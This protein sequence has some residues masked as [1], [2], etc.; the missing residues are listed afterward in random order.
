MKFNKD[1][2]KILHLGGHKQ[3]AQRRLGSVWLGSSLAKRDLGGLVDKQLKMSQQRA[4]AAMKVNQI[5]GCIGRAIT[6][7]DVITP[8][9]LDC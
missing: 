9:H 5:L 8:P 3:G 7:R 2:N 6:N 4:T 1:K